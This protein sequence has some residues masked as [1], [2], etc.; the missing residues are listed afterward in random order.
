VDMSLALD[1]RNVF[2]NENPLNPANISALRA[3]TSLDNNR[4][5]LVRRSQFGE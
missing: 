4:F 3:M 2:A 5:M 1:Q